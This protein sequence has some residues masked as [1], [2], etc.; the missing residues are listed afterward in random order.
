MLLLATGGGRLVLMIGDGC[1]QGQ[2]IAET[3]GGGPWLGLRALRPCEMHLGEGAVVDAEDH[4]IAA[5]AFDDRR[6]LMASELVIRADL[7][8]S[9]RAQRCPVSR[10][11]PE[12]WLGRLQV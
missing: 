7:H 1:L 2:E 8:P 3:L 11:R 5:S 4:L 10:F 12:P 9:L 6:Q